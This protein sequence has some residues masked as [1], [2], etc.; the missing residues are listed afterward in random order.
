MV[1]PNLRCPHRSLS[2]GFLRG[3][4]RAAF[5]LMEMLVVVV[6]LAAVAALVVSNVDRTR[7]D[8]ELT[9]ARATMQTMRE[10]LVGSPAGPGYL[11]DMK[12]VPGFQILAVRTH[13][14]LSPTSY[15][16]HARFDPVANRGWRGP[17]LQN[18]QG[19]PNANVARGGRFPAPGEARVE[20]EATFAER[21][22]F[23]AASIYGQV[24]DL[25]AADPWGS[26]IVLQ[27]P[28]LAAFTYPSNAA[29]QFRYARLVSAGPDGVLTVPADRL[30]SR[31]MD[32]T[33]AL[34]GDDVVLFL[35]RADTY[36]PEEN[37]AF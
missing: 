18:A 33:A 31:L 23:P 12:H 19:V 37:D 20:G 22:F 34:R 28:P 5:T 29:K 3:R 21:G 10:A 17:Y 9:V 36:E 14:L 7:D 15:P 13:D 4:V 24:D 16:L 26:P 2:G 35:D 32:G 6:I 11:S 8:A 1:Y 30:A 25:T 27:V